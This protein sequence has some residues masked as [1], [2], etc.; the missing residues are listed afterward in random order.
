MYTL[1][2]Q[3]LF[4]LM[5]IGIGSIFGIVSFWKYKFIMIFATAFIGSYMMTRGV[6]LYLGGYPNEFTLVSQIKQGGTLHWP[7]YIYM[8]FIG[9]LTIAGVIV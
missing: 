9:I 4:W 5:V 7:F 3:W 2:Q 6:S 8:A 1:H